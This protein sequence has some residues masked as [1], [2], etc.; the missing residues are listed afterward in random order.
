MSEH[1]TSKVALVEKSFADILNRHGYGFQYAVLKQAHSL[2]DSRD[3]SWKFVAAEFPVR[4]QGEDTR[5]DFILKRQIDNIYDQHFFLLAECKRANPALSNWC[6]ARAPYIHHDHWSDA[7]I[8]EQAVPGN[9]QRVDA[10]A[11]S[12]STAHNPCHIAVEVRSNAKGDPTGES[13]QAIE[14]AASQVSRGLNG[15][16]EMLEKHTHKLV[17][18]GKAHFLPVIFTTAHLWLSDVDLSLADIQSGNIDLSNSSFSEQEWVTYQYH[19]S[20]GIKHSSS[21]IAP[22]GDWGKFL[23]TEYIRSIPV[24]SPNGIELFLKWSSRLDLLE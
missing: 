22:T 2:S 20:P 24:V 14:K 4:V 16:I 19:L 6:F 15:M 9:Q 18:M 23:N 17:N 12:H 7:V 11:I 10:S 1:D 13:K 5:I 8:L 3:S 21:P